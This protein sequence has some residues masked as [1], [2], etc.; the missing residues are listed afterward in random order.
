[1][2][3]SS[4]AQDTE[5]KS[6][7]RSYV[8]SYSRGEAAMNTNQLDHVSPSEVSYSHAE[9]GEHHAS[10]TLQEHDYIGL[11]EVS[12]SGDRVEALAALAAGGDFHL[13]LSETE[14]RLGPPELQLGIGFPSQI[15]AAEQ[16]A[17]MHLLPSKRLENVLLDPPK[18][19]FPS[20]KFSF[21]E[22]PSSKINSV[23]ALPEGT[24]LASAAHKQ[25]HLDREREEIQ[26][27]AKDRQGSQGLQEKLGD[28][29]QKNGFTGTKRMFAEAMR[30][31]PAESRIGFPVI[32]NSS[33]KGSSSPGD[34]DSISPPRAPVGWPPVQSFRKNSLPPQP[35]G[36]GKSERK[37]TLANP[38]KALAA[39]PGQSSSLLVKVYM[40]GLTIGRKVDLR[41]QNSYDKLF[42]TLEEMFRQ[43]IHGRSSRQAVI[44]P[45]HYEG[46][47][48]YFLCGSEYVLTY[49]DKDGDLMLVG[50]VPWG[51]FAGTV[52]RLRIMKGSEAIGLGRP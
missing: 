15:C 43:Y 8:L 11:S 10:S 37:S 26:A 28:L 13:N 36:F 39:G 49:E 6:K 23:N 45:M 14:L 40:D 47:K 17:S 51:M 1:M 32:I 50:D 48:L 33:L 41:M 20:A 12:S 44:N 16:P 7:D 24:S 27:S 3:S 42:S 21:Q 34:C 19:A 31:S 2:G 46:K 38:S 30:D 35:K 18:Q 5:A 4:C 29:L 9:G 52:K 22:T 25:Q